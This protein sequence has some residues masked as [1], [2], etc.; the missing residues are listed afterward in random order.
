MQASVL[1]EDVH[2]TCWLPRTRTCRTSS[3]PSLHHEARIK[4]LRPKLKKK[5][6]FFIK[7]D[8]LSFHPSYSLIFCLPRVPK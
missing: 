4:P 3:F 1:S 7:K 2:L 8:I 6:E 5:F